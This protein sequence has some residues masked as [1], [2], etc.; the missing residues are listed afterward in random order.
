[1]KYIQTRPREIERVANVEIENSVLTITTFSRLRLL[2]E[3]LLGRLFST[4]LCQDLFRV[5]VG[6]F[7]NLLSSRVVATLRD[8]FVI[9]RFKLVIR[10][11]S[12]TQHLRD[13]V[14]LIVDIIAARSGDDELTSL[15]VVSQIVAHNRL[16]ENF[17]FRRQ[18]V[19]VRQNLRDEKPNLR[20]G[21]TVGGFGAL[22]HVEEFLAL[23]RRLRYHNFGVCVWARRQS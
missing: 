10:G 14:N 16:I 18:H 1:M 7:E 23:S 22:P 2:L 9:K 3:A 5:L 20:L 19:Q 4:H 21:T 17:D 13:E 15:F 8:A 12:V 6:N 11:L